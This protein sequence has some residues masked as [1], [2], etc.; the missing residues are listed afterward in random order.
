M[1]SLRDGIMMTYESLAN[2]PDFWNK[3]RRHFGTKKSIFLEILQ[4]K[5]FIKLYDD[6]T[7]LNVCVLYMKNDTHMVA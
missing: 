3:Q 5:T 2:Y 6:D 4:N 1:I 7:R